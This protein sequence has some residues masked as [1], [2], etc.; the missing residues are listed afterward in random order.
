MA[1]LFIKWGWGREGLYLPAPQILVIR[2]PPPHLPPM[3]AKQERYLALRY[4]AC[5]CVCVVG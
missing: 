3:L 1:S 4:G 5:V 2:T